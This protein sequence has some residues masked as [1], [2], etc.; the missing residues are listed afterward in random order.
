MEVVEVVEEVVEV[1][2]VKAVF[3]MVVVVEVEEGGG[4]GG[5]LGRRSDRDAQGELHL[6]LPREDDRRG[7]LGRVAHDGDDYGAQ[8]EVGHLVRVRGR[9]G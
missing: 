9:G 4:G 7:V 2:V 6:V 3:E 1:E 5:D 8:E